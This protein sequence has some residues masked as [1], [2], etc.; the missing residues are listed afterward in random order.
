MSDWNLLTLSRHWTSTQEWLKAP[1][2]TSFFRPAHKS[3]LKS[4]VTVNTV[5]STKVLEERACLRRTVSKYHPLV[6]I[7]QRLIKEIGKTEASF[8]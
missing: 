1:D 6:C 2:G 3:D 7:P 4:S 5:K 8:H